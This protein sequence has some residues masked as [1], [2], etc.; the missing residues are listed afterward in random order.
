MTSHE[1]I[2]KMWIDYH[3]S[4]GLKVPGEPVSDFFCDNEKDANETADLVNKGIKRAT[5]SSLWTY[6]QTQSEIPKVGGIFI[7]KDWAGQA[8]CVV[9]TVKIT[10][11]PFNEITEAHAYTEGEGDRTLA[12][13]KRVHILFYQNELKKFGL[14]FTESM[15]VIF[16]EF[17]KVFPR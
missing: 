12:Y 7:V 6:E 9:K 4:L 5:A 15:P 10:I 13:W 3:S 11:I 2:Q 16:E 17:E 14:T 1:S 8:V